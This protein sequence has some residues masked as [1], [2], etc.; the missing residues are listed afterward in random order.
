MAMGLNLASQET[1]TAV[2]PRPSTMVVERVWLVPA[3]EQE[4][5]QTAD[6]AGEHHGADDDPVHLDAGVAGGALA[7]AHHG[8]LIA[9]LAVVEVDVHQDGQHRHHQ[10]VQQVLVAADAGAASRSRVLWLMMPILPEPLGTS[11]TMM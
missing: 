5:H 10:D 11:Q 3:H 8:D 1:M 4:A 7:L 2:K 9:V 6:R